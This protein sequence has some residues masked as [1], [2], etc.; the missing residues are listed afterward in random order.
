MRRTDELSGCA[1]SP[2]LPITLSREADRPEPPL[3]LGPVRLFVLDANLTT[4]M[5]RSF[6]VS[7]GSFNAPVPGDPSTDSPLPYDEAWTTFHLIIS[8]AKIMRSTVG[9]LVRPP[10]PPSV[11]LTW[12]GGFSSPAFHVAQYSLDSNERPS[13]WFVVQMKALQAEL[14]VVQQAIPPESVPCSQ[15]PIVRVVV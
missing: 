12:F 5:G 3:N 11:H 1:L 7:P 2:A 15:H 8:L 6:H 9:T 14:D 13:T 10:P 4:V